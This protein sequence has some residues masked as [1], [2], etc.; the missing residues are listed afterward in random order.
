[1]L[2]VIGGYSGSPL[3]EVEIINLENPS[4]ACSASISDIPTETYSATPSF[5][6]N[7]LSVCGGHNLETGETSA[8]YE[9]NQVTNSWSTVNSLS[10]PRDRPSSSVIGDEWFIAGGYYD[11]A[12]ISTEVRLDGFSSPGPLVPD[13]IYYGCQ[14]TIN[15]THVFMADSDDLFT[16]ILEW[17]SKIWS[18]QVL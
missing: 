8:C 18:T 12:T 3:A 4:G 9:Y 7:K 14:V 2:L 6:K 15:E 10:E 11:G 13:G 1:M 5:I 16:Y 17:E